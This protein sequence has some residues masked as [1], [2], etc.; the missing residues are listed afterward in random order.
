MHC[1]NHETVDLDHELV[2]REVDT[3]HS[4]EFSGKGM[5]VLK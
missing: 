5:S 2:L 1:K 3:C 4:G